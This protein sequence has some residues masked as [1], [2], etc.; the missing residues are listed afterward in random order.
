[1]GWINKNRNDCKKATFLMEKQQ[2]VTL[3]FGAQIKLRM[4]LYGCSWCRTY[5]QQSKV[6]QQLIKNVFDDQ[7]I[8]PKGLRDKYKG[9][10]KEL[11]TNKLKEI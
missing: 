3:G 4:H 6:M 7:L 2:Q 10:L 11:I 5:Q 8:K 9:E 1:M